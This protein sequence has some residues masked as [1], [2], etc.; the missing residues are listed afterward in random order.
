MKSS[1]FTVFQKILLEGLWDDVRIPCEK[2]SHSTREEWQGGCVWCV[3]LSFTTDKYIFLRF[4]SI[5]SFLRDRH[6]YNICFTT[7]SFSF[8]SKYCYGT[9][10]VFPSYDQKNVCEFSSST[11]R[12]IYFMKENLL[13]SSEVIRNSF[14]FHYRGKTHVD[15]V[16]AMLRK[17]WMDFEGSVSAERA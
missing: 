3:R 17:W 11:T 1:I 8:I 2:S 16:V 12:T 13:S 6:L 10:Y 7:F 5:Y 14:C 9:L 4:L 15:K